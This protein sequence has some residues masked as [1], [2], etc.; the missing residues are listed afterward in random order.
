ML[1]KINRRRLALPASSIFPLFLYAFILL[2]VLVGCA[3]LLGCY[4]WAV[5]LVVACCSAG[6]SDE[7]CS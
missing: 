2:C 3:C 4:C 1:T 6:R 5:L 7:T